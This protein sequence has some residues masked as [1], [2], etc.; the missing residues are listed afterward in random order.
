MPIFAA[1]REPFEECFLPALQDREVLR[2]GVSSKALWQL[3][4]SDARR[5]SLP[6]IVHVPVEFPIA[7]A[8]A[9]AENINLKALQSVQA[10]R[11]NVRFYSDRGL[12]RVLLA[13]GK[14]LVQLRSE[15]PTSAALLPKLK[16]LE[17]NHIMFY[18]DHAEFGL[19]LEELLT[20]LLV[21]APVLGSF[22]FGTMA[23]DVKKICPSVD[24][25]H[26]P[27]LAS[28][29]STGQFQDAIFPSSAETASHAGRLLRCMTCVKSLEVFSLE[30]SASPSGTVFT[31][32]IFSAFVRGFCNQRA[33]HDPAMEKVSLGALNL[34]DSGRDLASLLS[35]MPHLRQLEFGMFCGRDHDEY[36][37]GLSAE[38]VADLTTYGARAL[39]RLDS[40]EFHGPAPA[41]I[42]IA[43]LLLRSSSLRVLDLS[44]SYFGDEEAVALAESVAQPLPAL[45]VL[46]LHD[47]LLE[48]PE[49]AAA[50]GR[51]ISVCGSIACLHVHR[52][53]LN[54]DA[55][56]AF[57]A[58]LSPASASC[59]QLLDI[60]G[61]PKGVS[62]LTSSESASIVKTM[63]ATC[64]HL[65]ELHLRDFTLD[66]HALQSLSRGCHKCLRHLRVFG[67][68]DCFG[69]DTFRAGTLL[70]SFLTA[71][72]QNLQELILQ[73]GPTYATL[74]GMMRLLS[75]GRRNGTTLRKLQH[76][77]VP[78]NSVPHRRFFCRPRTDRRK[79]RLPNMCVKSFAKRA[80]A[81]RCPRFAS[82]KEETVFAFPRIS[83]SVH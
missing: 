75:R 52:H 51:F 10:D 17:L 18:E 73:F 1:V 61:A 80:L 77:V 36:P 23:I 50:L 54:G 24:L 53:A 44:S 70:A 8:V 29:T 14:R 55:F 68:Y 69:A 25:T 74:N 58:N 62:R 32:V 19:E 15:R 65:K 57:A 41:G 81:T 39:S 60:G 33:S 37:C 72:A 27:S 12:G 43:P 6:H 11:S 79:Y 28:L 16:C 22:D 26:V 35:S 59:L 64:R 31:S 3:I 13:L 66:E 20:S 38:T 7:G 5:L 34:S 42:N 49:G 83:L 78:W 21:E 47:C 71:R 67:M 45:K 46:D 40:L 76:I 63:V 9:L 2:F 56:R 48:A 4:Y 30:D 82:L